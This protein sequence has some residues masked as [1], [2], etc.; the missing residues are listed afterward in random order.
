MGSRMRNVSKVYRKFM[1]ITNDYHAFVL[2]E[3]MNI[4]E[5]KELEEMCIAQNKF[6]F[7]FRHVHAIVSDEKKDKIC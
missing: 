3:R 7:F 5:Q 1:N 4:E 6:F 2:Y